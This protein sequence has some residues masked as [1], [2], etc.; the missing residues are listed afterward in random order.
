[1]RRI[2]AYSEFVKT[3]KLQG[4]IKTKYGNKIDKLHIFEDE[5]SVEFNL[6][7]IK[8]DQRNT[9]IATDVLNTVIDYADREGKIVKLTPAD[10]YGSNLNRLKKF[11]KRFGFIS[12]SGRNKNFK[13]RDT[14][15]RYPT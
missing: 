13:Y 10:D 8:K 2:P 1:M 7:V 12:N 4:I 6:I 15:L 5:D 3:S 9:G 11:Y 14:M